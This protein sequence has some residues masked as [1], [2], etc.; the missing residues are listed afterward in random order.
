MDDQS[1]P[2]LSSLTSSWGIPR[3]A[4]SF[5]HYDATAQHPGMQFHIY[6]ECAR[7]YGT[8]HTWMAFLDGDEFLEVLDPNESL[9]SI[10]HEL[11]QDAR[12]GALGMNWRLHSSAGLLTRPESVRK[13]FTQ[14]VADP[15]EPVLALDALP[16]FKDNRLIKSVVR[17]AVYKSSTTAH[18]FKTGNGTYTVGEHGDVV[19]DGIGIR[20]PITRDRL[21]VHHYTVKSRAQYEEKMGNW[22]ND[23]GWSYWDHI[24]G[25]PQEEC[26]EMTRYE[27]P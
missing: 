4:L 16:R 18:Y 26:L 14:C 2:P 10:L 7:L 12:V 1:S 13:A 17:T 15:E 22:V 6:D 23:K 3:T 27:E 21:A 11:E 5:Q 24:E 9:L 8:Q 25:L 19:E 20:Q